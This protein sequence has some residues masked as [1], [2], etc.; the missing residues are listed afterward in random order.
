M[1]PP[2]RADGAL[3]G[4]GGRPESV[5]WHHGSDRSGALVQHLAGAPMRFGAEP[6]G[7]DALSSSRN[8]PDGSAQKRTPKFSPPQ[9][10]PSSHSGWRNW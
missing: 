2:F 5:T 3:D 10:M 8:R 1:L 6:F 4:D 7:F 9:R